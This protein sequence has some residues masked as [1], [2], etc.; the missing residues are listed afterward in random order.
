MNRYSKILLAILSVQTL[1]IIL[2]A[3]SF[4]FM[5]D[6]AV[7]I[8][9]FKAKIIY[10]G[11]LDGLSLSEIAGRMHMTN[12]GN[13]PILLPILEAIINF[14]S[15]GWSDVYPKIISPLFYVALLVSFFHFLKKN[16]HTNHAMI[17]TFFLGT[18]T[19]ITH[20]ASYGLA[21]LMFTFF[22]FVSFICLLLWSK[23]NT[24]YYL[25]ISALCAGLSM[26]T[27]NEGMASTLITL[28]VMTC[29]SRRI[30]PLLIYT[31]ILLPF[32][33]ALRY[34]QGLT[35]VQEGIINVHTVT[36]HALTSHID[37]LP[38]IIKS[39]YEQFFGAINKW[40]I[41]GY[42][43]IILAALNYKKLFKSQNAYLFTVILLNFVLYTLV[44]IFTPQ[45]V[46]LHMDSSQNRI[47]MHFV[48]FMLFY[49]GLISFKKD[50]SR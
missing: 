28:L 2:H 32:F 43:F 25:L 23:T 50:Y 1:Y 17:F 46:K 12:S 9:A 18:L 4:P 8:W 16:T 21:D 44:Y 36:L 11:F 42:V 26:W 31:S 19:F 20:Q 3:L 7:N 14:I 45:N 35:Q 37:R 34:Y 40:N 38:F 39:F 10:F 48:P 29:M 33:I 27:K 49:I 41:I 15:G 13:Y 24:K 6:D 47:L 30:R 22:Y 5:M